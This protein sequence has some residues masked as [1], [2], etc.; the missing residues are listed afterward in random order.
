MGRDATTVDPLAGGTAA[1]DV[2]ADLTTRG[3]TL[4]AAES[5]TAGLFCATVAGVPG[6]SAV[7]RGGLIT[8]ATELK[9]TL[10]GVPAEVLDSVGPVAADTARAMAAGARRRC[11]AD[12]GVALTG[13]AGPDAQEGHPV[14]E[15]W[16]GIAG[17]TPRHPGADDDGAG[18]RG[19]GVVVKRVEV[20]PEA[21]RWGIR[22]AS[23]AAALELLAAELER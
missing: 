10:A 8:Y 9:E 13:V 19:D 15:V 14:G 6:A 12:W 20:D 2:V 17:P 18:G 3:Q 23:V 21:G 7:L 22:A 5:L 11:G 4:A 16:C 1:A